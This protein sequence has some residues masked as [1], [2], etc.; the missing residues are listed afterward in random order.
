M[1]WSDPKFLSHPREVPILEGGGSFWDFDIFPTRQERVQDFTEEGTN[2][3]GGGMAAGQPIMRQNF[4][5]HCMNENEDI[6]ARGCASIILL[7]RSAT[8]R[9]SFTSQ[10]DSHTLRM[11]R[12]IKDYRY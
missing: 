10:I 6:W 3:K 5:K 7:C 11:W 8:A 12:L 9:S 2:P 4:P 1:G